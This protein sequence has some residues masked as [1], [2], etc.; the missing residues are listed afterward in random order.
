MFTRF[1]RASTG[2]ATGASGSGLGLAIVKSLV[3]LH[4]GR[5]GVTAEPGTGSTF[6]TT[7]PTVRGSCPPTPQA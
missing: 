3:E 6:V 2:R 4:G 7:L 1:F 5:V